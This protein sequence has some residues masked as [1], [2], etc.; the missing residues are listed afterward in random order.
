MLGHFNVC[1]NAHSMI[2]LKNI[3]GNQEGTFNGSEYVKVVESGR[4]SLYDYVM[5]I[6]ADLTEKIECYH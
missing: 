1:I 3:M 2:F 5:H 6:C 4:I